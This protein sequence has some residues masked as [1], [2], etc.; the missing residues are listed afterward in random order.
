[1]KF[2]SKKNNFEIKTTLNRG[3]R[4][5]GSTRQWEEPSLAHSPTHAHPHAIAVAGGGGVL[6]GCAAWPARG[7]GSPAGPARAA[8]R[9]GL[10]A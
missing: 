5:L 1:M 6:A 4:R 3:C 9:Q 7:Q 2:H 10:R 8:V